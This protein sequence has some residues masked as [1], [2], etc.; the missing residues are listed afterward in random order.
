MHIT[1][2]KKM[3]ILLILE[4]LKKHSDENHKLSQKEI[5]DLMEREYDVPV[6]RHTLKRNLDNL[7][8]FRCGVEYAERHR[9]TGD[10]GGWYF[11]RDITDAELRMLIDGLLFSKFI[12]YS[13]CK[14]LIKKLEKLSSVDFKS[15]YG[16]P[17]N[18]PENKEIF[19]SIEELLRAMSSGKKVAFN[20]LRY[21][22]D[23]KPQ[24]VIGKD[25]TPRRY[26]VS[27]YEIVV[28]NGRYYLIGVPER[29]DRLFHFR[30]NYMR[31]TEL[32]KS[33]KRRPLREIPGYRNGI[34]LAEYM[35][36]HPY[37]VFSGDIVRVTFR[38]DISIVDQI[39]DWFGKD[40]RFIDETDDSVTAVVIVNERAMLYWALQY[41]IHVEILEP[42]NLREQIR[43]AVSSMYSKYT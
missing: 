13:E 38:A 17:E 8:D 40:V 15:S 21:G 16:L 1:N 24:I 7:Y 35:K 20:Y 34:K 28:T 42:Q 31:N 10:R 22:T 4:I 23:K 39:L 19:L 37:M 9:E 32:L 41:G 14:G 33:E 43:D 30:L 5:A 3:N 27:P 26:V 2:P 12:P 36:A 18:R 11:E 29:A 25:G 6:D